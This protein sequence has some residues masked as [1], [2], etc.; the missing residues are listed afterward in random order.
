MSGTKG[1]EPFEE[2]TSGSEMLVNYCSTMVVRRERSLHAHAYKRTRLL[3]N[4]WSPNMLRKVLPPLGHHFVSKR[5]QRGGGPALA[6]LALRYNLKDEF[7][8]TYLTLPLTIVT[9]RSA[10]CT[11]HHTRSVKRGGHSS[12]RPKRALLCGCKGSGYVVTS[13]VI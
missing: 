13:R 9:S 10:A 5:H 4:V 12:C 7:I 2:M 6:R 8:L 1:Q 3:I 11:I